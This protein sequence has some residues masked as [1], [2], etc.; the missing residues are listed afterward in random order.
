MDLPG[1]SKVENDLR[2]AIAR[3]QNN[4]GTHARLLEIAAE[5]YAEAAGAGHAP[6]VN[7]SELARPTPTPD[8][9]NVA[10][11]TRSAPTAGEPSKA[12]IAALGA[13][14]KA[15]PLT[16]FDTFIVGEGKN[17]RPIGE[18]RI[19]EIDRLAARG[20]SKASNMMSLA[21]GYAAQASVLQAVKAGLAGNTDPDMLI[22]D[23][24][25]PKRLENIIAG[26]KEVGHAA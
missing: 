4:G 18:I 24:I 12:D 2:I 22:R 7:H 17:R 9:V 21:G 14:M 8:A 6:D 20:M 1:I 15:M 23:A 5:A 11:H 13:S 19:G 25:S 10:A 3:W 26:V 16:I